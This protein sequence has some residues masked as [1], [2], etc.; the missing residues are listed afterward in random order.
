[1]RV[2]LVE[3]YYG[4]SH[5]VWAN[6]Y[7][8]HS[9]HTV[10]LLTLP[11]QFWK[12]RMQGG[13]VTLAR[14]Y[15]ELAAHPAVLLVSEMIDLALFRALSGDADGRRPVALY[16]HENQLTYP[17]NTRQRHGWQYGFIN[18][19]SALAADAVYFN[20]GFHRRSFLEALPRMLKHFGDYHELQ[21]VDEIERKASVLPPGVRLQRLDRYRV[22]R[23]PGPPI[24]LWNHRWEADKNPRLFLQALY[25]LADEGVPFRVALVG[26]NIRRSPGEF[27]LARERLGARVIRYGYVE[28]FA[29]YAR[30]LWQAD[31]VISSA[32]QD[33]FG[34]AVVEAMYCGCIPLLP[35]RLN[36]PALIPQEYHPLLLYR[37]DRLLPLLRRHLQGEFAVNR[38]ALRHHVAGFDWVQVAPRYDAALTALAQTE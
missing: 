38:D 8:D 10:D 30:L 6:G 37:R 18:Y 28:T 5:K 34:I 36:Y 32:Y 14:L 19:A 20:S 11:A 13:A 24:I 31:Y 9:A 15:R 35:D 25:A 4:G 27:V 33:F 7:R 2:L 16:M 1:M 21:T 22:A 23:P 26:E 17:Q 3:P 12:W 29:E